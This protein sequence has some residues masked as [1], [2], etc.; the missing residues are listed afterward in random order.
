MKIANGIY[1]LDISA[2]IMGTQSVINPTLICDSDT[3]ILIDTGFPGQ[4]PL[5]REAMGKEG[6]PFDRLNTV[7]LTHQDIDHVGCLTNILNEL[8]NR[9]KILAHQ[10]EKAYIQGEKFPVK[11]A[12]L[13]AHLETL[14]KEATAFYEKMKSFYENNKPHVDIT[15]ADGEELP[16]CGG[17]TVIHTPGHTPGHISLY[18]KRY[19]LLVAGDILQVREGTLVKAPESSNFDEVLNA[20]SLK[21]IAPYD[22]ETVICYHGG[23]FKD[24]PNKRIAELI[25]G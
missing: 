17:I 19:K 3:V 15:I 1:I 24:E 20:E 23:I 25:N 2:T 10:E 21:K 9:V 14:P 6:V 8:P 7:I 11:V 16:Y 13:E 12:R 18:I 4:L 5:I 22:I